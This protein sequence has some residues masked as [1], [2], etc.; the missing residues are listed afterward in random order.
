MKKNK[1]WT[2]AKF[3]LAHERTGIAGVAASK[4]NVERVKSIA[5]TEMDDDK[6]CLPIPSSSARSL[7]WKSI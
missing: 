4:R 6:P 3:L 7:N 1:G 2:C 5:R